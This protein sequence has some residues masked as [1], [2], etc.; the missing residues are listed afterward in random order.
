MSYGHSASMRFRRYG[1]TTH[2]I[3]ESAEDLR[4]MLTLEEELWMATGAPIEGIDCDRPF[5][6]LLDA[7][8]D[9]RLLC[10]DLKRAVQWILSLLRDSAG[11][12]AGSPVLRLADIDA[13][14][15]EGR[16]IRDAAAG[17]LTRIGRTGEAD[18]SLE[19]VRGIKS[20]ME[21][22][23][24]SAAGVVLEDAAENAGVKAFLADIL[25]TVGGAPHPGG[26]LGVGEEH[27][28]KFLAEAEAYL[29]WHGKGT[30]TG[31]KRTDIMPLGRD[32]PTAYALLSSLR[33]KLDQYFSQC[34]IVAL[35]AR[36][37]GRFGPVREPEKLDLTE[38]TVIEE[39]LQKSPVSQPRPERTL[40]FA[41]GLNPYF[42]PALLRLRKE[43]L[44]PALERTVK[45]L[46]ENDW[47]AVK[48]FFSAHE[49]WAGK[50]TKSSI[51][52]LEIEKL[53]AYTN[54]AHAGG[55]RTLIARG[56]ATKSA[57]DDARLV[58]KLIL[59]QA[60]LLPLVNNF[61]SFPDLYDNDRRALFEAGTLVMDGRSFRFA[62]RVRDR[63]AHLKL[64]KASHM[65]VLY[66]E[67][68]AE[69]AE[70]HY[71]VAVPV[72][73]G[74]RG[75]LHVGKRGLFRDLNG[76]EHDAE[77]VS[78]LENPIGFGE[79]VMA[80]FQQIGRTLMGKIE[81]ITAGAEKKLD[82]SVTQASVSVQQPSPASPTMAI[83]A[84]MMGTA[85]LG[86]AGA[87]ITKTLAG[88]ALYKVLAGDAMA[89]GAVILPTVVAAFLKLRR[90]DLSAILEASGWTINARMRLT[91]RQSLFFTYKPKRPGQTS[92]LGH[93][94]PL[95]LVLA[96]LAAAL[97]WH[98][99]TR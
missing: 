76:R 17:M 22:A 2:L 44:E 46:S 72:T 16:R 10:A 24:V 60:H 48:A 86:S 47:R 49:A 63:A 1:R 59:Y 66:I 78:I 28:S 11:A 97:Y 43:V 64:A 29:I 34:R 50:K 40:H 89:V 4:S 65:F 56:R 99:M 23:P 69:K 25:A 80:P 96:A 94:F 98:Q 42:E 84:V 82:S 37:A 6:D 92:L 12:L 91:H 13:I 32:T 87:F 67:V 41:E 27:L 8:G 33:G 20:E 85:A 35:D 74:G 38:S 26:K 30:L 73:A 45:T 90:R 14:G 18:I 36:L 70:A 81:S 88:I 19:E 79:A 83:G 5:L 52:T 51:V 93:N 77:V 61:V 57:L 39:L 55:I 9:G 95:L 31:K 71:E 54:G 68:H 58:E 62:V 3:I 15:E 75:N 21:K 53:R 7:D